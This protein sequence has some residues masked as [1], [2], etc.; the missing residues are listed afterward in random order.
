MIQSPSKNRPRRRS[1]IA[2]LLALVVLL[3]IWWWTGLWRQE[4]LLAE[5]RLQVADILT[6]QGRSLATEINA[7]LDILKS[8]TTFVEERIVADQGIAPAEF[9]AF[10]A[11]LRSGVSGI[12]SL[13]IA[14]G[15]ITQLI[16]PQGNDD[17]L[18]GK[19]LIRDARPQV[20]ADVQRA[21]RSHRIVIGGPYAA[22]PRG[23]ELIARKAV[24]AKDDL[25][26]LVSLVLDLPPV[27][28]EAGLDAQPQ[29]LQIALLDR[30]GRLLSGKKNVLADNPVF[31]QVELPDGVWKLAALPV[32]GWTA[33]MAK[34]LLLFR[35]MT[36][37][38]AVLMALLIGVAAGY[39]AHVAMAVSR[40][41]GVLQRSLTDRR[42]A[43]EQMSRTLDS[44]RQAMGT[45]LN[46]LGQAVEMKDPCKSGHHKRVADLARAIATEMGLSE[47]TIDGIRMASTLHDIGKIPL[48]AEILSK[49]LGL[50]EAEF[51]LIKTHVQTG[52]D[53]LND[54][55]FPWP[56]AR[57]VHQHH[58]R[59]NG[60]GY[61]LG[62]KGDEILPEA[63]LLAVAD[64]V[65]AMVSHRSYRPMQGLDKVLEEIEAQR[66][67]LYD[68]DVVDACLR[69]FREKD[70]RLA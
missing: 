41:T 1:V 64:V 32:E 42:E 19:D 40:R 45:T 30:S 3:P 58:E 49:P 16:F 48:P 11:G 12:R 37:A 13:S 39:Q 69:I 34:P 38:I 23:L 44:L 54:I 65:E 61:P 60:S 46:A 24:Y 18:I 21:V 10:G 2:A 70:F 47:E 26:G 33:A 55:A 28:T 36:L 14:P 50:S 43:G 52:Y 15:A 63:R 22:R 53:I 20:R 62:L 51:H 57:I 9:A 56:V 27:F 7:R 6:V 4:R 17:S 8:L 67:I 5:Q 29:G 25:W 66:G 59:M 68:S 35:G 31:L